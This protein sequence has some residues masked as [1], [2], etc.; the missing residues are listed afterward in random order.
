MSHYANGYK[1]RRKITISGASVSGSADLT[2]FPVLFN[3]TR[4]DYKDLANG[5]KVHWNT[6]FDIRF[7]LTNGTKLD[8][9]LERWNQV[10]GEIAAWIRIPTL[11]GTSDTEFYIYYGKDIAGTEENITGVWRSEYSAVL[12]LAEDPSGSAP[13]MLDSTSNNNDA[14]SQGSMTSGDAVQGKIGRALEFDSNDY[15]YIPHATSIDPASSDFTISFW[16]KTVDTVFEW[17]VGKGDGS[18]NKRFSIGVNTKFVA[19]IS[20]TVNGGSVNSATTINDN[21][22][23]HVVARFI[24]SGN[25]QVFVDGVGETTTSISAVGSISNSASRMGIS[26]AIQGTTPN[27][28]FDGIIDEF[29]FYKAALGADWIATE[30]NNQS[31]PASFH[32][33]ADEETL[34]D[35]APADLSHSHGLEAAGDLIEHIDL[36]V[37]DLLHSQL[38]DGVALTQKH[39]LVVADLLHGHSLDGDLA[40]V[41]HKTLSVDDLLHAHLLDEGQ[42]QL[43]DQPQPAGMDHAHT[44]EGDLILTQKHV[45]SVDDLSHGNALDA[46]NISQKHEIVV[47]SLAHAHNVENIILSQAHTL[48]LQSLLHGHT[49]DA[50][51]LTQKH[52]LAVQALLHGHLLDTTP[53]YTQQDLVVQ[54]LLHGH[55]AGGI[56]ILIKVKTTPRGGTI[57]IVRAKSDTIKLKPGGFVGEQPARAAGVISPRP[58]GQAG[59]LVRPRINVKP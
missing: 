53:I 11:S 59:A 7:E 39:D 46:I 10:T 54:D 8:H 14:T 42:I 43:P 4:T 19:S 12:H 25:L 9:E 30:Y 28:G 58:V 6:G 31:N 41:E 33:V 18:A 35:L 37:A 17:L 45:L 27:A 34:P 29:R 32:T 5:G 23:H 48:A 3:E 52:V 1:Y 36:D 22:W 50:T 16:V 44:L 55:S 49:L 57:L 20:D 51:V 15:L 24:R 47:Q 2:N 56:T 40:L 38:L 13:Q 21:V 26:A